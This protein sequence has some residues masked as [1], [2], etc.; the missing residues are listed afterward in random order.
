M[1]FLEYIENRWGVCMYLRRSTIN[2]LLRSFWGVIQLYTTGGSQYMENHAISSLQGSK[3]QKHC[4]FRA[5]PVVWGVYMSQTTHRKSCLAVILRDQ[6][7]FYDQRVAR[8]GYWAIL[9][10]LDLIWAHKIGFGR[11]STRSP[12]QSLKK[13]L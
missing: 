8:C 10:L 1:T 6:P 3:I 12:S 13:T 5:L 9:G 7:T 2:S 4:I 11:F